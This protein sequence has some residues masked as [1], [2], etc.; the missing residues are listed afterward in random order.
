MKKNLYLLPILSLLLCSMLPVSADGRTDRASRVK[1][2]FILN[3]A[4]YVEWPN[5]TLQSNEKN[6]R[7]CFL[8]KN[9][10]GSAINSIRNKRIGQRRL[11]IHNIA[12]LEQNKGCHIL[13]LTQTQII[14]IA[15]NMQQQTRKERKRNY[16]LLFDEN[17]LTMGDLSET[18]N[19]SNKFEGV[20]INLIRQTTRIG[21][22]INM[23]SLNNSKLKLSSELLKLSKRN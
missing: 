12:S 17:I 14:K 4:R 23:P 19:N 20:I 1:A 11:E 21:I 16:S 5:T 22:Q 8:E 10:L 13:F 9:P 2:A 6:F 15:D 18:A 3:I 7:L